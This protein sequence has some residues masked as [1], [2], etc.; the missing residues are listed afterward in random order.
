MCSLP[1][2]ATLFPN[3]WNR[4]PEFGKRYGHRYFSSQS[5]KWQLI[6]PAR[7]FTPQAED[8]AEG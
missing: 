5:M 1:W 7:E 8:L 2:T 3:C 4:L 6:R